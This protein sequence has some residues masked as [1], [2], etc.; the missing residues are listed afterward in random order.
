MSYTIQNASTMDVGTFRKHAKEIQALLHELTKNEAFAQEAEQET[1]L[2]MK[3]VINRGA[4]VFIVQDEDA[5][6]VGMA[7]LVPI[8]KLTGTDGEVHDVVTDPNHQGKGLG[9]MLMER[10]IADARS[11]GMK[12]LTLTSNPDN[13]N[14]SVARQLYQKLGFTD[15]DGYMRMTL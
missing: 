2:K 7:T 9:R 8:P 12:K 5:H 15:R 11:Q 6:F 10:L 14:R 3:S 1:A 4:T 13:P